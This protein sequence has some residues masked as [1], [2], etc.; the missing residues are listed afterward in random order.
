MFGYILALPWLWQLIC[1]ILF[2]A[3]MMRL[4]SHLSWQRIVVYSLVLSIV[5]YVVFVSLLK[6]P[7]PRGMLTF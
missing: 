1:S 5:L 4:L 3:L 6:V 2:C 7:M